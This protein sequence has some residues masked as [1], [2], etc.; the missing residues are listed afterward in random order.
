MFNIAIDTAQAVMATLGKGGF[1]ASPLAMIVA[2]MGAIQLAMVA[3]QTI[4]QYW[5]GT[6]NAEGGLA[7]T[8]ERGQEIIAD[9]HGNIK[10]LGSNKGATL[11]KLE[12]GDKVFTAEKTKKMLFDENLNNI[13]FRNNINN[14]P[15]L[16][17]NKGISANEM[18]AIMQET[19][20]GQTKGFINFDKNGFSTYISKNGNI[21]RSAN[22]RGSATGLRF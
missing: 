1:F 10:S 11:T 18:K 22:N 19:I 7:W 12:K 14:A 15:I 20:G 3:S 2:A 9:R 4:P 21:T 13:L 17:D 6:E 16:I 8:Q 5:K